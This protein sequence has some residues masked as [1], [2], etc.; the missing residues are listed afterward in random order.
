MTV[1]GT[2]LTVEMAQ[3]CNGRAADEV[4]EACINI[5]MNCLRQNYSRRSEVIAR[6]NELYGRGMEAVLAHYDPVTGRRRSVVPFDQVI[7][8]AHVESDTRILGLGPSG[9]RR[10]HNGSS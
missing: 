4:F 2:Q 3:L 7:S 6:T 8:A 9:P 1:G 10:G 5:M